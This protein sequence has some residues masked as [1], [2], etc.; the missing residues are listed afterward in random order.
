MSYYLFLGNEQASDFLTALRAIG[1]LL[2]PDSGREEEVDVLAALSAFFP[3]AASALDV[4]RV[5]IYAEID[6]QADAILTDMRWASYPPTVVRLTEPVRRILGAQVG[7]RILYSAGE[8]LVVSG[9]V[10]GI[11]VGHSEEQTQRMIAAQRRARGK[12]DA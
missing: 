10:A 9:S 6:R 1:R 8:L 7:N 2:Q 4:E 5:A 3:A 12:R 11:S